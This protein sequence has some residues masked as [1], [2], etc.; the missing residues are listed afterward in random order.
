[1][2]ENPIDIFLNQLRN[3]YPD[4]DFMTILRI[5]EIQTAGDLR[6]NFNIVRREDEAVDY[7]LGLTVDRAIQ[8]WPRTVADAI[9]DIVRMMQVSHEEVCNWNLL[10]LFTYN[11]VFEVVYPDGTTD[12]VAP[13]CVSF[14]FPSDVEDGVN[15]LWLQ[16]LLWV[17][18]FSE[19]CQGYVYAE[20]E[21]DGRPRRWVPVNVNRLVPIDDIEWFDPEN[22]SPPQEHLDMIESIRQQGEG[23]EFDFEFAQIYQP[24]LSLEGLRAL[25]SQMEAEA[26][27][28]EA[29]EAA[30]AAP[31]EAA[32]PEAAA[33]EAA[34][35]EAARA[36]NDDETSS[37]SS[38]SSTSS[39][40]SSSSDEAEQ[41]RQQAAAEE[42]RRRRQDANLAAAAAEQRRQEAEAERRRQEAEAERRREEANLAAA[43]R[44]A[45]EGLLQQAAAEAAAAEAET[46][47][48]AAIRIQSAYR[49]FCAR[50]RVSE[51]RELQEAIVDFVVRPP[52]AEER[53]TMA[54]QEVN[55]MAID[56][57][58][59][60][61]SIVMNVQPVAAAPP[62]A[63]AAPPE[64]AAAEA[65][66]LPGSARREMT[67]HRRP[68]QRRRE[69]EESQQ[70]K[71][72]QPKKRQAASSTR[73][74][75][76]SK[77]E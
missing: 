60:N 27:E 33:P 53:V 25:L 32:A 70:E 20:E 46:E 10:T 28:A 17:I 50:R 61:N 65:E 9:C 62:E 75:K 38:S 36:E 45:A 57:D 23:N 77:G 22:G 42:A 11:L 72:R 39:S 26:A 51:A 52:N 4:E 5:F 19:P 7:L 8:S 13:T 24:P 21:T 43:E 67:R 30:E 48:A 71:K 34:A 44:A 49:C 16:H 54:Q 35:P 29:V 68:S 15:T 56:A 76:K 18:G 69:A 2:A 12:S 73:K 58:I 40:T 41:R 1:M 14:H 55:G 74:G 63:A 6:L 47:Q 64:A 37:S 66:P 31:P 59:R 3:T